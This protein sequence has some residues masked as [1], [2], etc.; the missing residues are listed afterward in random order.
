M[1]IRINMSNA[2]IGG[3]AKV[4]NNARI[5]GNVD[6]DV[7]MSRT[8]IMCNAEVLNDLRLDPFLEE[9]QAALDGMDSNTPE[10]DSMKQ[11][12]GS[13]C[14]D[15]DTVIGM[16]VKH[17]GLFSQGVLENVLAAYISRGW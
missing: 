11:I 2:K 5:T 7:E 13:Q 3:N 9:L 16:I 15:R 17:I 1:G 14:K 6:A 4:L 12:V 8:E 10:Y